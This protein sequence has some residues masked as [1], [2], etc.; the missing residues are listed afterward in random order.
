M[1]VETELL[2]PKTVELGSVKLRT[3]A[4]DMLP[5]NDELLVKTK[6]LADCALA[7]NEKS[8]TA[9]AQAITTGEKRR[10]FMKNS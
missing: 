4:V 2:L 1:P 8:E 7:C 5:V 10:V 6:L 9:A 3:P